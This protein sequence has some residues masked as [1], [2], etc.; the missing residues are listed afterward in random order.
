MFPAQLCFFPITTVTCW[1]KPWIIKC[2][3]RRIINF[4]GINEFKEYL[5]TVVAFIFEKQSN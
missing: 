1:A 3:N 2:S 5:K 4:I